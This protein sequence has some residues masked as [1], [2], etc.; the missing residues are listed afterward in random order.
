[1]LVATDV[2]NSNTYIQHT[3]IFNRRCVRMEIYE[4]LLMGRWLADILLAQIAAHSEVFILAVL[5]FKIFGD[6]Q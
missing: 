3:D 6:N 5:G 4:I 1:M 2:Y